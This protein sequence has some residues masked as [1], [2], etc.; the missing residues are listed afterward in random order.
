MPAGGTSI[1]RSSLPASLAALS[2]ILD[3]Q[4][5]PHEMG[6]G[7]R[8]EVSPSGQQLHCPEI[9]LFVSAGCGID[10]LTAL[11]EGRR[12]EDDK[13][14]LII[15]VMAFH[16]L[17]QQ[18]EYIFRDKTHPVFQMV[19]SGVFPVPSG[20]QIPR[21]RPPGR[22]QHRP[23]LH[24]KA[25]EPV[26]VKQSSTRFPLAS[27]ATARRLY[28]WSRKKPVFCPSLKSTRY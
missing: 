20:W 26:W 3:K 8:R 11:G 12:I 13:V 4:S 17:R 21:Y 27:R 16:H 6:A 5:F 28:F 24:S 7:R 19:A 18:V 10:R 15:R 22:V 2:S 23:S 9:D 14:E 25:N 1:C